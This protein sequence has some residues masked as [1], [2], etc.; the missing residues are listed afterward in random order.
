MSW[1]LTKSKP[2]NL[3]SMIYHVQ[4]DSKPE[5]KETHLGQQLKN[6]LAS[7]STSSTT[8][9]TDDA[10]PVDESTNVASS[11]ST[12]GSNGIGILLS[13]QYK[14]MKLTNCSCF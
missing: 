12:G 3:C 11:V 5:L 2:P 7:R 13:G 4:V 10:V 6:P 8:L 9:K 14:S 1:N